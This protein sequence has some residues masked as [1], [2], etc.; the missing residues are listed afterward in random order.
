MSN[1]V[2]VVLFCFSIAIDRQEHAQ[3]WRR[4]GLADLKY[5][6][7]GRT[8]LAERSEKVKGKQFK[9]D[10][11]T[12]AQLTSPPLPLPHPNSAKP[13]AA[14]RSSVQQQRATAL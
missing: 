4:N 9:S 1:N 7:L 11:L 14:Q 12:P 5:K 13:T 2:C 3:T 8:S 6:V 10:Q